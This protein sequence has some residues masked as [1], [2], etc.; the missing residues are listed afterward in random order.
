MPIGQFSYQ[1]IQGY[2]SILELLQLKCDSIICYRTDN[3]IIVMY[4]LR[5]SVSISQD[6]LCPLLGWRIK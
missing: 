5:F 3:N 2:T 6:K 1:F 4:K